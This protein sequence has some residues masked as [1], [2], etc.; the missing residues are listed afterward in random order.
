MSGLAELPDIGMPDPPLGWPAAGAAP[1]LKWIEVASLRIDPA[2]Q[3]PLTG[4]GRRN[5]ARIAAHFRWS[6]FGTVVVAPGLGG[7][8][9]IIDGM[10]R[11]IAARARGITMVPCQI[12][13]IDGRD[14]A[15]AFAA[16]NGAV[17]R[18]HPCSLYKAA[19]AAGLDWAV[20]LKRAGDAAGVT[21]ATRPT[22]TFEL[23]SGQTCCIGTL[24]G[25]LER[26]GEDAVT[27]A[28]QRLMAQSDA[29][30]YLN[31]DRMR[32]AARAA[33]DQ[34]VGQAAPLAVPAAAVVASGSNITLEVRARRRHGE[35]VQAIAAHFKLPYAQVLAM[36]GENPLP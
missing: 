18:V 7:V 20:A 3:R 9:A 11:T 23:K 31:A 13:A 19:L 8:F 29:P 35:S 6:K 14:Q 1:Q 4:S 34:T 21:L 36:S 2:Y 16:I 24:R 28:L 22:A 32:A 17:T 27:C 26:S 10:H 12:V 15:D 5:I 33:R 30:G 25:M